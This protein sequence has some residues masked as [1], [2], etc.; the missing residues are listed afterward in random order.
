MSITQGTLTKRYVSAVQY[1]D[2]RDIN[3]SVIDVANDKGFLTT[4]KAIGRTKPA[5][6]FVYRQFVNSDLF[7]TITVGTT[8]GTGTASVVTALTAGSGFLRPNDTVKFPNGGEGLVQSISTTSGIDTLTIVSVDGTNLTLVSGNALTYSGNAVGEKSTALSSRKYSVTPYYNLLQIFR[9]EDEITDVQKMSPVEFTINGVNLYTAYQHLMKVQALKSS[10]DVAMIAGRQSVTQFSDAAP[11]LVDSNGN[12]IQKTMG[13]DQYTT[14]YGSSLS[15]ATTDVV[16]LADLDAMDDQLNAVKA[17]TDFMGYTGGKSKRAYDK[18]LKNLGSAGV[19]SGRLNVDGKEID[20]TV[21]GFNYGTR[22][23]Q[24]VPT[25]IM[26]HPKLLS[27]DIK[28]S[29]YWI[30]KDKVAT[31]GNGSQPRIQIRY[32]KPEVTG[33]SD[34][35]GEIHTGAMAP[36]P[37]DSTMHWAATWITYQGLECL[38]AQ[39]FMKQAITH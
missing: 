28:G 37:T 13:L 7:A 26:N 25:S 4:M 9:E 34:M 35:I 14:T 2:T 30:P 22:S 27:A 36:V 5:E 23:Y 11:V 38:G 20:L 16:I 19:T 33:G 21:D 10:V 15:T 3:H 39:H 12:P 18:L 31:V 6:Q 17:P 32:K 24:F 8:T 29:I 1:L